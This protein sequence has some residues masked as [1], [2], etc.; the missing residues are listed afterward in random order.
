[1]A[2]EKRKPV[3]FNVENPRDKALFDFAE[4]KIPNW[5]GWV[6]K[7]LEAVAKRYGVTVPA[8]DQLIAPPPVQ[9][10]VP[11]QTEK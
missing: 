3:I 11:R 10:A 1:M 4:E 6:K 8:P 2:A 7:S 5:S 9:V